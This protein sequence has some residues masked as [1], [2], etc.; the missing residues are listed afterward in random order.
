MDEDRAITGMSLGT[1]AI[2]AGRDESTSRLVA[3]QTGGGCLK[4]TQQIMFGG[5]PKLTLEL[6]CCLGLRFDVHVGRGDNG[7]PA[8]QRA[9]VSCATVAA[10][11]CCSTLP[12][13]S[14]I[15]RSARA[16]TA[17]S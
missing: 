12:S 8:G 9:P 13:R 3:C 2:R 6:C 5:S 4:S 11:E 14:W 17:G 10:P 15:T 16:A 1:D 7:R